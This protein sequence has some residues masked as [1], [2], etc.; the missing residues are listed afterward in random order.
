MISLALSLLLA[1]ATQLPL[2]AAS[3]CPTTP[4]KVIK[5]ASPPMFDTPPD[6]GGTVLLAVTVSASGSVKSASITKSSGLK[7]FDNAGLQAA[8]N[9]TYK[10][11]TVN[12]KPVEG[13]YTTGYGTA[14]TE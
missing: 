3:T 7:A 14:Y 6:F 9:S 4:V 1:Q 10:P 2:P 5:R 8:R 11:K 13:T 12:C